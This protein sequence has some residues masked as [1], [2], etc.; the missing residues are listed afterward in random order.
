MR[1]DFTIV[2]LR[3]EDGTWCRLEEDWLDQANQLDRSLDSYAS[4]SLGVLRS[5]SAG[6]LRTVGG[7]HSKVLVSGIQCNGDGRFY[8]ACMLILAEL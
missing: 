5:L 2:S 6:H 4:G 3:H 7:A 8:A 1:L